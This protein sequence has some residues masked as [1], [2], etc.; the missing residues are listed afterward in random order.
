MS[1]L[2]AMTAK[3]RQRVQIVSQQPMKRDKPARRRLIEKIN[4]CVSIKS[5]RQN[6]RCQ[7][8]NALPDKII[9]M[10]IASIKL[11]VAT[12]NFSTS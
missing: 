12:G 9:K 6:P 5:N 1:R 4:T 10:R 7:P 8:E 11:K 2:A 3:E